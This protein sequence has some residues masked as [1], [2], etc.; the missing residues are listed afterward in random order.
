MALKI[1]LG[2]DKS[3]GPGFG[4]LHIEGGGLSAGPLQASIQSNQNEQYLAAGGAWQNAEVWHD[5]STEADGA[6]VTVALGPDLVDPIVALP[7]NCL[8]R[9]R[10]KNG[11]YGG[12]AVRGLLHSVASGSR[13]AGEADRVFHPDPAP[14]VKQSVTEEVASAPEPSPDV[15]ISTGDRIG[16]SHPPAEGGSSKLLVMVAAGLLVLAVAGAGAYFWLGRHHAA[17]EENTAASEQNEAAP[18]QKDGTEPLKVPAEIASR[19]D[20]ALYIQSNPSAA[21]ALAQAGK[22]AQGGKLDLAMLVYQYAARA[23]STD[24]D[25]A[26]AHM[27]DPETWSAKT[28][29][30]PQADAETAAYW[31]EPAA[32]AGTV[33]AQRRLGQILVELNPS[34]FQHDKGK[35]WLSKAAAAGDSKA[36]AAFDAAK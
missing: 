33:E 35:E 10:V 25:M 8:L 3:R 19:G 31:Y 13:P 6:G 15:A 14:V 21:D 17:R 34:G 24:A 4:R 9:L 23:G 11:D 16:L 1:D 26:L 28:S 32:Q 22:L 36:K 27:Y 2:P 18:E 5:L 30:M 29:P 7:P 20:V 12:I